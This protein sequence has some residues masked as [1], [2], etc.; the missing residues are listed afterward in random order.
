MDE[1]RPGQHCA[2]LLIRFYVAPLCWFW[3]AQWP[4]PLCSRARPDHA[5]ELR[6]CDGAWRAAASL[7]LPL[8]ARAWSRHDAPVKRGYEAII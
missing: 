8:S 1:G 7:L 2:S 3:G 4:Q 6:A 5:G